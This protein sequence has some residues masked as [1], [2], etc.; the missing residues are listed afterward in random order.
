VTWRKP[1]EFD[2]FSEPGEERTKKPASGAQWEPGAEGEPAE[3]V[4]PLKKVPLKADEY[5][6][7]WKVS[8]VVIQNTPVR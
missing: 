1:L 7:F 3:A 6:W 4:K 2:N 5:E 8:L